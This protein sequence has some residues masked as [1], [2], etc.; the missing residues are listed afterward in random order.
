MTNEDKLYGPFHEPLL[1]VVKERYYEPYV[2]SESAG[3]QAI[4]AVEMKN[5]YKSL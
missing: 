2:L 5:Y 3:T 1:Q 4:D